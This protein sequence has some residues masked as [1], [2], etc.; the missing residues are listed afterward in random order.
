MYGYHWYTGTPAKGPE[1]GSEEK[2]NPTAVY[3]GAPNALQL[4][5]VYGGKIQWD[6][7]DHSGYF[8]FRR[9]QM[10]EWIFFTVVR[11]FRDRYELVQK[12]GLQGF[13]SQCWGRRIRGFGGFCRSGSEE[14]RMWGEPRGRGIPDFA[15]SVRNDIVSVAGWMQKKRR[16][17]EAALHAGKGLR[18]L[19]WDTMYRAPTGVSRSCKFSFGG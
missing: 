9:D 5:E 2:P 6:P 17:S 7:D 14:R 8:Y 3:I 18:T 12:D 15:D 16:T 4:A 19:A 11:T 13:C 1:L 10:R